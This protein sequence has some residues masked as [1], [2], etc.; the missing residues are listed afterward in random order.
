MKE[1]KSAINFIREEIIKGSLT[2]KNNLDKNV[3]DFISICPKYLFKIARLTVQFT[4]N[5]IYFN[6]IIGV[7]IKKATHRLIF[8]A[9]K[10]RYNKLVLSISS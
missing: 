6:S 10:I 7:S 5:Y 3:S 1:I 2:K 8:R 4:Q 9:N